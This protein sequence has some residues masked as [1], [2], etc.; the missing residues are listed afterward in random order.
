[1]T[2][3]GNATFFFGYHFNRSEFDILT[4]N[5]EIIASNFY[6]GLMTSRQNMLHK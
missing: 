5:S 1:M 4:V 3:S 6:L 2:L